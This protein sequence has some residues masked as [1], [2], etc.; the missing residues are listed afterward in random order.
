MKKGTIKLMM[1]LTVGLMTFASCGG[2][3]EDEIKNAQEEIK[4]E[5]EESG[6]STDDEEWLCVKDC[7]KGKTYTFGGRCPECYDELVLSE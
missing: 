3:S 2:S 1:V 4:N 7:E 5:L 6:F